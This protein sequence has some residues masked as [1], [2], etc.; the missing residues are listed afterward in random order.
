MDKEQKEQVVFLNLVGFF[1]FLTALGFMF[2]LLFRS[3]IW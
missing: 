1:I 3:L 2:A